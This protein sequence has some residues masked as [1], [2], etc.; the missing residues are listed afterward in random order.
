MTERDRLVATY[1]TIGM[2]C[3]G[4][5]WLEARRIAKEIVAERLDAGSD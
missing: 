4:L 5:D 1:T 2:A 3:V